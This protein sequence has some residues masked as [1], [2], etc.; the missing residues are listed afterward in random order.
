[1]R[2]TVI[3]NDKL[4][5]EAKRLAAARNTTLSEIVN[6]ALRECLARPP[7][8]GSAKSFRMPVFRGEGRRL[9]SAPAEL[10]SVEED[11]ELRPYRS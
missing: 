2:T 9:D 3:L 6:E 8:S 7:A 1:M 5:A 4:V 11:E 10:A